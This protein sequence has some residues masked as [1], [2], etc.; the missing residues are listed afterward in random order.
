MPI[1]EKDMIGF[2][3]NVSTK[4]KIDVD[5]AALKAVYNIS[6]GDMRKAINILQMAGSIEKID[7]KSIYALGSKDP[8]RVRLMMNAALK[9]DFVGSRDMLLGLLEN[10]SGED[11]IKEMHDQV[12]GL[13]I[14]DVAKVALLERIG[15]CDFRL[16][17]GANPRIQLGALLAQI[18]I[19]C[20]K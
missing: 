14:T 4:E 12:F 19:S 10:L 11:I 13:A 16:T 15:E 5:D 17:E 2:L 18:V 6:E 3:K 8:E 7:E 1:A 9:G 20:K